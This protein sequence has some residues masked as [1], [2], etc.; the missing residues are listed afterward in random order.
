MSIS[1]PAIISSAIEREPTIDVALNTQVSPL[2]SREE[3]LQQTNLYKVKLSPNG[4]HLAYLIRHKNFVSIWLT[5][6]Q[7][8]SSFTLYNA[9]SVSDLY[10]SSD[11]QNLFVATANNIATVSI[12]QGASPQIILDLNDGE[13]DFEGVDKTHP[14]AILMSTTEE[15]NDNYTLHR[16]SADRIK[17]LVYSSDKPIRNILLNSM[18]K[19]AFFKQNGTD[20]EHVY[21]VDEQSSEKTVV[22]AMFFCASVRFT[23]L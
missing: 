7:T 9:K 19:I 20:S 6:T 2:I 8:M 18:G 12:E 5:N 10:W 23:R 1:A 4:Q 16:L 22:A 21:Y 14:R 17:T 3:F 13:Y 15:S 11:S